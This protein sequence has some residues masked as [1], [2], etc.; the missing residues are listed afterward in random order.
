[1]SDR[2]FD[3]VLHPNRVALSLAGIVVV[4]A[5][6]H[7]FFYILR[8]ILDF[9]SEHYLFGLFRFFN[10]GTEANLPTYVSAL[11]LLIAGGLLSLIAWYKKSTRDRFVWHWW[12]LAAGVLLMSF[13]EAAQIH[14]GIVG[15][16][17]LEIRGHGEGIW[18][19][20]WYSIF[21]PVT[22]LIG[23]A[24]FPFLRHLPRRYML[25]FLAA[26]AVFLGGAIGVEMIES[27]MAYRRAQGLSG[28]MQ[29]VTF[30][31]EET[32]EMLGIVLLIHTLLLYIAESGIS[33]RLR[34]APAVPVVP[35]AESGA[36][37][38]RRSRS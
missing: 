28:G 27:Y 34:V 18:Y 38:M 29:G 5:A 8:A 10:M 30:L 26:A 19:Y 37:P 20:P 24:Y 22:I 21:I 7:S 31:V 4:L 16:L 1:M 14:E 23:L 36:T 12:V 25:R 2:H 11:N 35:Y 3:A 17:M 9:D 32:A 13:D 33:L 15:K 6:G